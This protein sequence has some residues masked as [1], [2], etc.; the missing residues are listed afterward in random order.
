MSSTARIVVAVGFGAAVLAARNV[1]A[2]DAGASQDEQAIR[3]L[4]Q[5][6]DAAWK[7]PGGSK[8]MAE[9][10]S[11]KGFVFSMPQPGN[12]GVATIR[13]RAAF[14]AA[15]DQI[16]T[17]GPTKHVHETRSITVLGPLA[18]EAWTAIDEFRNGAI[19]RTECM[20]VYAK[21]E[22]GWKLVFAAPT[23]LEQQ[24]R[25]KA[26]TEEMMTS[27]M[28]GRAAD[29]L[30][31]CDKLIELNPA[32]GDYYCGRGNFLRA[33]GRE[34]ESLVAFE[35]A[36]NFS[37]NPIVRADAWRA[38]VGLL[39]QQGKHDV[40]IAWCTKA[41]EKLPPDAPPADVAVPWYRRAKA[42][43]LTGDTANALADLKKA[44]ELNPGLKGQAAKDAAFKSLQ[45]N[46][47]FKSLKQ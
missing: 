19:G 20:N 24:Q 21:D 14:L 4:V 35:K 26:L 15:F 39:T 3:S 42:R 25:I 5:K 38:G 27:A 17:N 37:K 33:L 46:A 1:W 28:A 31:A 7:T 9:V 36:V 10:I 47:E 44:I 43:A 29:A 41:I 23:S 45:D 40:V 12:P 8:I 18:Y 16:A 34:D 2:A 13:G 22:S 30:V 32:E 6:M 11:E